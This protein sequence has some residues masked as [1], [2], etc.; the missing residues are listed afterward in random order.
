MEDVQRYDYAGTGL[1][2]E[3]PSA[4]WE[5]V[6]AWVSEARAAA[7][8][9]EDLYEPSAMA[10]ATVDAEGVPNV[11]TV[12]LRFLDARG[13][14]YVSSRHSAKAAEIG[15]TG[16]MAATL[17]W[18]PLFRAI[19]FRGRAQEIEPQ[20]VQAYWDNRPWG[21]KI[22]AW[23]SQQSHPVASRGELEAA[24][25][26]FAQQYPEEGRESAVPAPPDWVGYRIRCTEVEFWAGRPDRLHDR[27]RYRAVEPTLLDDGQAWERVRLQP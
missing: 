13:P 24:A 25:E 15:A 7:R 6:D 27:I 14:G 8:T 10:V 23:A 9:R 17:T 26:R 11:R 4:P 19:R 18:S 1:E 22:S 12:L 16:V 2:G 20:I 5:L 3:V 21:S